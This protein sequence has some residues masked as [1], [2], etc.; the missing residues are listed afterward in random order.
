MTFPKQIVP[1]YIQLAAE[2]EVARCGSDAVMVFV[3]LSP[4][5]SSCLVTGTPTTVTISSI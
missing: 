2:C 4:P 5:G 3:I 1:L